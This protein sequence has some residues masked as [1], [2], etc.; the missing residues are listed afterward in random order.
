NSFF[1]ACEAGKWRVPRPAAGTTALR[2]ERE[3]IF[4]DQIE[5]A[6]HANQAKV[7][8][9]KRFLF[10]FFA[11]FAGASSGVEPFPSAG[12]ERVTFRAEFNRAGRCAFE[13]VRF[14]ANTPGEFHF[15]LRNVF[16]QRLD[17]A[18]H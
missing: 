1:T 11:F 8:K 6:K 12:A 14:H 10:V 7:V 16:L 2:M 3:F 18:E 13:D 4:E 17:F 9:R 15:D 5:P